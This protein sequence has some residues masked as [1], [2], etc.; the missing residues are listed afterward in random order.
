MCHED[1]RLPS[2]AH[3]RAGK[4]KL[5]APFQRAK[6]GGAQSSEH[7]YREDERGHRGEQPGMNHGQNRGQVPLTGPDKKKPEGERRAV[8][9]LACFLVAGCRPSSPS[10]CF[11]DALSP[12]LP[13]LASLIGLLPPSLAPAKSPH[14]EG[15]WERCLR[16]SG[17]D[18]IQTDP[19]AG[20]PT[21]HPHL[22]LI[23]PPRIVS[24]LSNL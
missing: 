20:S 16:H 9:R 23:R 22:H 11:L 7:T 15:S 5:T 14:K 19:T 18:M 17:M 8:N 10:F 21:F 13:P 6:S 2:P 12:R 24:P 4:S 3:R 1:Q